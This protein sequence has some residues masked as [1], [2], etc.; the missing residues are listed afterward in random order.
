MALM[1]SEIWSF[2]V[3]A[4][5]IAPTAKKYGIT[6]AEVKKRLGL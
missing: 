2:N 3:T 6:E 5:D 1:I 4:E